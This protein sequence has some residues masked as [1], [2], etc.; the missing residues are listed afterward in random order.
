MDDEPNHHRDHPG[1]AGFS[2]LIA[3]MTFSVGREPDADLAVRLASVV[4][5]DRVVDVGCGPGVAMRR[6]AS[7]GAASVVGVDPAAVMLRVGRVSNVFRSHGA[8]LRLVEGSAEA[9]PVDDGWA[10]VVWSL[11]T[12]HHW[13]DVDLGLKEA[14]RVLAPR[15][16]LLAIERR[17]T[18]GATGHASHGW[19]DAQADS[20]ATACKSVGFED[21]TVARHQTSREVLTVLARAPS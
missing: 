3:A 13:H 20:F 1:F 8:D 4:A 6:A 19:T 9:L 11:S 10:T 15:G 21:V 17:T 14:R 12:V 7:A 5:G 16:R 18:S 2:G